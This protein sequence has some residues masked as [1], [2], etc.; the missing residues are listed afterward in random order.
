MHK[1]RKALALISGGLDSLLAAKVMLEQ[2]LVVEGINFYSGFFG[3]GSGVT[4]ARKQRKNQSSQGA[5]WIAHELNIPLHVID[6]VEAFK[7][8]VAH[9]RHGYGSQLNPCLDCKIFIVNN[10]LAFARENGFDF[11]VSGEV[12]GQRPMSQ[13]KRHLPMVQKQSGAEDLLLRPLSAQCLP[14]TLPEREGWVDREKLYSFTGRGRKP[15]IALAQQFGFKT[16]PQPAGGCWL[17]EEVFAERLRDFW[18]ARGDHGYQERDIQLL[19]VARH[20]R[21][22]PGLKVIIGRDE[23]DNEYLERYKNHFI[24]A[25]CVDELGPLVLIDGV[26]QEEDFQT[27]ANLVARY[28]RSKGEKSLSIQF[29]FPDRAGQ[30]VMSGSSR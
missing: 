8:I 20:I 11:L 2:G 19:K 27:V 1:K 17:T 28:S 5:A 29:Q 16:F 4:S 30:V 14:P 18:Q 15:Q 24:Y 6:V 26:M 22:K 25:Q 23:V 13:L 3:E 21:L 9:P 10:A 7:P 12:L